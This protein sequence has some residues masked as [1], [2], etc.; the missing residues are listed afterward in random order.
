MASNIFQSIQ[1]SPY[2]PPSSMAIDILGLLWPKNS[3]LFN[4][5]KN[6]TK[7]ARYYEYADQLTLLCEFVE[8]LQQKGLARAF[9]VI[10]FVDLRRSHLTF[11]GKNKA[12]VVRDLDNI[13]HVFK[14]FDFNAFLDHG[15]DFHAHQRD[16]M[17]HEICALAAMPP[18]RNIMPCPQI[19]VVVDD[20]A[21]RERICGFLQPVM[22][23]GTL[24]DQ[25]IKANKTDL[26][27]PL[28]QQARWCHGMAAG[29]LHTHRV[30]GTY[31]MDVKPGNTLIDDDDE[32]RLID[33]E[34]SGVSMFT[35]SKEV[36][37]DQAAEETG[38]PDANGRRRIVYIP[39]EDQTRVNLP[40]GYPKWN[41][42][43]EWHETCP[44]AA[45][46]AEVFSLGRVMWMLFERL[47]QNPDP[48][49]W[50]ERSQD[51]P[52]SW[53]D[54]SNR[55]QQKDPNDRPEL[56]EVV[57]FW[58]REEERYSFRGANGSASR[59]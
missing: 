3:S 57:E 20:E 48:T 44:R 43:P 38:E 5:N 32:T 30:G 26:R 53:I 6:I 27:I 4:P 22:R 36:T 47:E 1:H 42:F 25:V 10:K 31:H 51:I 24:D 34:Q 23:T 2:Q 15:P 29:L 19:L 8:S 7:H 55:C 56:D 11:P 21:G 9:G 35:H 40:W 12:H 49:V 39:R 14:G 37:I 16:T 45:E 17:L 41:V 52:S 13:D 18:H 54:M 59:G 58:R 46:L 33:W 50:T 28:A